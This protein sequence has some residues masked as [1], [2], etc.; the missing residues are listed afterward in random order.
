MK[1]SISVNFKHLSVKMNW[2]ELIFHWENW[3]FEPTGNSVHTIEI[4]ASGK[5][6]LA[7]YIWKSKCI[8]AY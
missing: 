6:L 8:L 3:N 7:R 2:E 1:Y 4:A 5:A